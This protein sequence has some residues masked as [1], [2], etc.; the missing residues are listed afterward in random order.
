MKKIIL[1]LVIAVLGVC[2]YNC[3]QA[4]PRPVAHNMVALSIAKDGSLLTLNRFKYKNGK[5]VFDGALVGQYYSNDNLGFIRIGA[6]NETVQVANN[7]LYGKVND[8]RAM[9]K[10][11]AGKYYVVNPY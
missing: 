2:G 3:V 1:S 10:Y 4:E 9:F 5:Y 8:D 6:T 7:P 11:V